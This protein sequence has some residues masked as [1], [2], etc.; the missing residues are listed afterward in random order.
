MEIKCKTTIDDV[1]LILK[2][3]LH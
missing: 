3:F 2:V 1:V